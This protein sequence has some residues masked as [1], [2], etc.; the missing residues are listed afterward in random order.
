M[1]LNLRSSLCEDLGIEYPIF[2]FSHCRDVVTAVS[3]SGGCGCLGVSLHTPEQIAI[4]ATWLKNNTDKP[5]GLD[6]LTPQLAPDRATKEELL[7]KVPKEYKEFVDGLKAEAGLPPDMVF[8]RNE[9][10]IRSGA[11]L[12]FQWAQ[13]D[14]VIEAKPAFITCALGTSPELVAKA[15]A[16][17]I[18]VFSLSGT[19]KHALRNVEA[20]A[21]AIIASGADAGGHTGQIGTFSLVPQIVDAVA[22]VP[23]LAAGGIVDGRGLVAARVLGAD[24]VWTGTI[25][26]TC[27]EYPLVDWMKEK[28]IAARAEDTV[29][30][31]V[32]SGKTVRF[33][34]NKFIEAWD[35]PGA[36]DTL[37]APL[38]NLYSS[39]PAWVTT[40]VPETAN[41]FDTPDKREW[42][43]PPAG[44][45]VG[46]IRQQKSAKLIVQDMINQAVDVISND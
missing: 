11:T 32:Y 41:L 19:V 39:M 2:A 3:N 29:I 26:Q 37:K 43:A 22:P 35:R 33:L 20:G 1:A 17:G 6:L 38:Q 9:S 42:V 34:K 18:R 46:L 12:E 45:A 7:E 27:H 36:P 30:T 16:A 31:K 8:Q 5:F 10:G 4:E 14:A 40:E 24:A 15:H 44:Q 28:L 23:V 21:D 25:W 13:V